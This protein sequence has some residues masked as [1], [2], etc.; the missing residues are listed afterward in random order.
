MITKFLQKFKNKKPK[1]HFVYVYK[2]MLEQKIQ[3]YGKNY[4][5]MNRLH[6]KL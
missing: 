6:K 4:M 1:N 2:E 3:I 5:M